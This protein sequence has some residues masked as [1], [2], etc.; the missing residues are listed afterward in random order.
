MKWASKYVWDQIQMLCV[1][2]LTDLGI[3]TVCPSKLE[4]HYSV[5]GDHTRELLQ[6]IMVQ[7]FQPLFTAEPMPSNLIGVCGE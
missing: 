3:A 5:V 4:V 1:A 7:K 2:V 6:E